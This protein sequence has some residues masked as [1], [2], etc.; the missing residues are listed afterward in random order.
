MIPTSLSPAGLI[1]LA[2]RLR[3][4]A[5]CVGRRPYWR[6]GIFGRR[7][8]LAA[9]RRCRRI[10]DRIST[11]RHCLQTSDAPAGE[12]S[13]RRRI[14]DAAGGEFVGYDDAKQ[15]G[16]VGVDDTRLRR[17]RIGVGVGE[18][19]GTLWPSRN[20]HGQTAPGADSLSSARAQRED[21][22]ADDARSRSF[23]ETTYLDVRKSCGPLSQ[24]PL[25]GRPVHGAGDP[26]DNEET[27]K[28]R[29]A[30][31]RKRDGLGASVQLRIRAL[32]HLRPLVGIFV[33]GCCF[34]RASHRGGCGRQREHNRPF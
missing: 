31:Q 6:R 20:A 34:A 1:C 7:A 5:A 23:W 17:E 30:P 18:A 29:S 8:E 10:S 16:V 33:S 26:S 27:L 24:T 4:I 13:P 11:F 2:R 21:R 28:R 9:T 19:A 14:G 25:A 15:Q 12:R 32:A 3:C 22:R